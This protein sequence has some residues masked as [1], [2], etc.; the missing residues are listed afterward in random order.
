MNDRNETG[1]TFGL[2]GGGALVFFGGWV[3]LRTFGIIPAWFT[4]TWSRASWPIAIIVI[5]VIV[6][7]AATRGGL[8]V[9]G[10]LP[11]SRLHRSRGDKWIAG[12]LGG[13]GSYLGMDPVILRLAFVVLLLGGWGGLVVAYIVMAIIVP[14]EPVTAPAAAPTPP[15][16]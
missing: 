3:L 11:G 13:L 4:E 12:V 6:L 8:A 16:A 2:I 14:L 1:R 5:G 7:V 10:P 15:E 9:R